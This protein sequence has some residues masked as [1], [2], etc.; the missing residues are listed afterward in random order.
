MNPTELKSGSIYQYNQ[1][2]TVPV[3]LSYRYETLN[4]YLFDVEGESR[5]KFLH[6]VQVVNYLLFIRD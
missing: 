3:L 2:G 6:H 4:Y 1:P 5:I